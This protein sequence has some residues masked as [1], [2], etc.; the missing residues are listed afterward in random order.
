MWIGTF[1]HT[2]DRQKSTV[3]EEPIL[4]ASFLS[5]VKLNTDVLEHIADDIVLN[6][7]GQGRK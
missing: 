3:L 6:D 2:G 1:D 7:L 4:C 5:L